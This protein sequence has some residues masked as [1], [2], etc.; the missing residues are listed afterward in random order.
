MTGLYSVTVE[1]TRPR[2][3]VLNSREHSEELTVVTVA[4]VIV[5]C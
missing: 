3:S 4:V 1:W 5:V 2:V